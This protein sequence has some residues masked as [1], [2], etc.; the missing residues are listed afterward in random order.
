MGRSYID[1]IT[2]DAGGHLTVENQDCLDLAERFG[3]PLF[4]ISEAQLRANARAYAGDGYDYILTQ[5]LPRL[6]TA[7]LDE[8][9]IHL[10]TIENPR[11]LLTGT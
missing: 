7:G 8:E 3:T 11:R 1:F 6:R 5:L 2:V 4:V 10:I 9:S